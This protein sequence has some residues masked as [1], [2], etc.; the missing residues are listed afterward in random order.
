MRVFWC[1]EYI[2]LSEE[3][4]N[5]KVESEMKLRIFLSLTNGQYELLANK[6]QSIVLSEQVNFIKNMYLSQL[7]EREMELT[8]KTY[9]LGSSYVEKIQYPCI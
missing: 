2:L 7:A 4:K 6:E 5:G 1:A 3:K 8:S 9:G